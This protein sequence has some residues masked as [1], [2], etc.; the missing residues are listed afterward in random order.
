MNGVSN[1]Y[2]FQDC[3]NFMKYNGISLEYY[4]VCMMPYCIKMRKLDKQTTPIAPYG[5]AMG[6]LLSVFY[7]ELTMLLQHHIDGL[8]QERRNPIALFL[9]LNHPYSNK[10]QYLTLNVRG[11]S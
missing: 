6:N 4:Q 7:E 2:I 8:V 10:G 9:A 1:F 5:W 3:E 11:P